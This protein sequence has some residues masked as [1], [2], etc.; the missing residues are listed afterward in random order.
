M[1]TTTRG[2]AVLLCVYAALAL[3]CDVVPWSHCACPPPPCHPGHPGHLTAA[4]SI[5]PVPHAIRRASRP[6]P[7]CP[8]KTPSCARC[9]LDPSLPAIAGFLDAAA[10]RGAGQSRFFPHTMQ[11]PARRPACSSWP[12][13]ELRIC[14]AMVCAVC[15]SRWRH[16][17]RAPVP[18][19]LRP[20]P[21]RAS[22]SR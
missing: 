12:A 17:P 21:P 6:V 8:I 4:A 19:A 3:F 15:E 16:E 1:T 10:R 18:S 13:I 2:A 11:R 7:P 14:S 22:P 5:A 9:T 20:F